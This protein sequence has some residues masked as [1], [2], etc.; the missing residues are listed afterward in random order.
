MK[1]CG[2]SRFTKARILFLRALRH[3]VITCAA[4]CAPF[5]V[6]AVEAPQKLQVHG[7]GSQAYTLTSKNNFFGESTGNGSFEATEL[8]INTSW[9]MNSELQFSGQLLL[10]NVGNIG[11]DDVQLDYGLVDYRFFSDERQH[12]GLRMGRIKNP[13]GLYN[14][15]RDVAFTRPG[16]ILPQSIYF[17]R[18]RDLALSSDGG[19]LYGELRFAADTLGW[20][21][22]V[23]QPRTDDVDTEVA[24][25]GADRVGELD[26]ET[27]FVGR[28]TYE[29][30]G[31]L[32][33]AVSGA[34]LNIRYQ[35]GPNDPSR[36]GA[37][38]FTPVILSGQFNS[39]TWSVTAEYARRDFEFDNQI[40]YVPNDLKKVTGE[41]YYLQG[42]YSL[43]QQWEL[44]TRYDAA[45]QNIDDRN[46]RKFDALVSGAIPRHSQ[47]SKDWT[48]GTRWNLSSAWM[49]RAE[50]HWVNGTAWLPFQDNPDRA[51]TSQ[52][53][54]LFTMLVSYRF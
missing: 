25:L 28:L 30:F 45:Y 22:V 31:L 54:R 6:R 53:W 34:M 7:F 49:F 33:L 46:G 9:R 26:G 8:G 14:D 16:V 38:R 2:F 17:E 4:F 27:S 20:E 24:F 47:F 50:H 5:N 18:T 41:S 23:A 44:I 12:H 19:E 52:Y 37:I 42:A 43:S 29:F 21:L 1:A 15:T 11:D 10:R 39:D 51:G 32:R 36:A 3:A 35:S 40:I 13:L 48:L